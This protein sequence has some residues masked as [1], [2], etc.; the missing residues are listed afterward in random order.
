[1]QRPS[2]S[3]SRDIPDEKEGEGRERQPATRL[4]PPPKNDEFVRAVSP[5]RRTSQ[6]RMKMA[7][8]S[9]HRRREDPLLKESTG[10]DDEQR[11]GVFLAVTRE[12]RSTPSLFGGPSPRA[13][14]N[15]EKTSES[16]PT[17]QSSHKGDLNAAEER[18][19]AN[20]EEIRS[21]EGLL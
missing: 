16:R 17:A 21:C 14:S 19:L 18:N 4:A 12:Q 20:L 1:M 13:L 11:G 9:P 8:V 6:P 10:D 3:G 7:G 15:R 2:H 5:L